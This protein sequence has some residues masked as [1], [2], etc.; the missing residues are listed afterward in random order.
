MKLSFFGG[1][2]EIGRS[3]ILLESNNKK[4]IIDAGIKIGLKDEF[5]PEFK[6]ENITKIKAILLSHAHLDHVGFVPLLL[7]EGFKGKIYCTKPTKDLM[8]LLLSD[9]LKIAKEEK[10]EIYSMHDIRKTMANIKTVEFKKKF[11]VTN[12]IKAKFFNSGHIIGSASILIEAEG[13]KILYTSDFNDRETNL[14]DKA[15]ITEKNVSLLLLES[16]YGS[17][18]DLLP[19]LKSSAKELC[20]AINK[21]IE[22]KGK[23]L[24]PVFAVGRAQEIML[25]LE[26]YSRSGFLRKTPIYLD[27]MLRKANKISRHNILYVR[28]EIPRRILLSDDDP[29]KSK[30]FRV[31]KSKKDIMK[32]ETAIILATSGMLSAGPSL[33]YF[34]LMAEDKKNSILLVGYQAQNTIGRKLIEGERKISIE[35]KVIKVEAEIKKIKFSGHADFNGLLN[36]VRQ[37]KPE[38]VALM[39]GEKEKISELKQAIKKK[40]KTMVLTPKIG[41]TLIF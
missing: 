39:H 24:I 17:K 5:Y 23:V 10:R 31:A 8:Q 18:K 40:T 30:I 22:R 27:G 12:G 28:K 36:L 7:R 34:K 6:P 25:I 29:F 1:V 19:A 11:N 33:Q 16:T 32:E 41:E 2:N 37:I 9:A 21:T 3:C 14:L 26:N 38:K 20:E 35:N 15:N 13:K 4:I